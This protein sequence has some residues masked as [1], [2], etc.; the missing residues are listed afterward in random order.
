MNPRAYLPRTVRDPASR[1]AMGRREV[2][3]ERLLDHHTR[4]ARAAQAVLPDGADDPRVGGGRRREIE[5]AVA[6]RPELRVDPRKRFRQAVVAGV[7][8]GRDEV[9][10]L[11]EARP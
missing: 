1:W 6:V 7:V 10:V 8:G 2:V 11:R 3:T 9:D 5:E 4:P